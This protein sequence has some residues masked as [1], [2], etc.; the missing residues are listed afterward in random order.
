[1]VYLFKGGSILSFGKFLNSLII[2][3]VSIIWANFIPKEIY[4][5]YKYLLSFVGI[6]SLFSLTGMGTALTQSLS[7]KENLNLINKVLKIKIK[8]SLLGTVLGL[9]LSAYYF[10][11]KSNPILATTFLLISIFHIFINNFPIYQSILVGQRKFDTLIKT[12]ILINLISS[13]ATIITI[14]LTENL[15]ILLFVYLII[16]SFLQVKTFFYI[17]NKYTKEAEKDKEEEQEVVKYGKQ[18]SAL[19]I[20]SNAANYLDSLIIF[21]FI[22]PVSLA[23]YAFAKALPNQFK[24][25]M[26]NMHSL[27]VPKVS[28]N[29]PRD[30]KNGLNKKTS[31][32]IVIGSIVFLLYFIFTPF[33]FDTF[34]PKYSESIKYTQLIA[35]GFVVLPARVYL[36]SIFNAHRLKKSQNFRTIF[37]NIFFIVT[38]L[39][40]TPLWGIYGVITS[41]LISYYAS[42][43]LSLIFLKKELTIKL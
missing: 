25:L 1:M 7:R 24:G 21:N 35:L 36:D 9:I 8:W 40:L 10:F 27:I 34:Y 20:L 33:V 2:F 17:K 37:T 28:G 5:Q 14:L 38:L 43:F 26:K 31:Y 39:I 16:N 29:D 19:G 13:L 3:G 41:K 15:I 32:L 6:F 30:I 4:G 42:F 22:S 18:L 11:L 23:V 12:N